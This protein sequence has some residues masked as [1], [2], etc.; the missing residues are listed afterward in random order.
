MLIDRGF[1][2]VGYRFIVSIISGLI[3]PIPNPVDIEFR[4][5]SGLKMARNIITSGSMTSV[6]PVL[7]RQTLTLKRGVFT[8]ASQLTT[9]HIAESL[10]WRNRMLF[11]TILISTV[12]EDYTPMNAWLISNAYLESWDWEGLNANSNELLIESMS[13]KYSVIKYMPLKMTKHVP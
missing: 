1:P 3:R 10:M 11:K 7:P 2:V 9:G 4:E 6:E 13:F 8:A 12:D 5:V